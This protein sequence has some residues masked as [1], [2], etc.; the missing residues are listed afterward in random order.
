[1][2]MEQTSK[3]KSHRPPWE[4]RLR[5]ENPAVIEE[6]LEATYSQICKLKEGP[7]YKNPSKYFSALTPGANYLRNS[8]C[9]NTGRKEPYLTLPRKVLSDSQSVLTT[10]SS[11]G[12]G[13]IERHLRSSPL[14]GTDTPATWTPPPLHISTPALKTCAQQFRLPSTSRPATKEKKKGQLTLRARAVV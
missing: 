2:Q 9:A 7:T 5:Q 12:G 14:S 3:S 13:H 11:L 1:M 10:S 4:S 6:L 8:P